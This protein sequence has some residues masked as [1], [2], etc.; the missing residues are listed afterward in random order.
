M[1]E[2]LVMLLRRLCLTAALA[3]LAHAPAWANEAAEAAVRGYLADIAKSG[4]PATAN[5]MHT[6]EMARFKEM[7]LP[8][9]EASDAPGHR[10]FVTGFFGPG[11]TPESVKT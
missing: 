4:I 11:T 9:F 6:E 7:L 2:G 8:L 3:L 1:V 10:E 5:H